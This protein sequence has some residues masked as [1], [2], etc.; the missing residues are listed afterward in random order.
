MNRPAL[1]LLPMHASSSRGMSRGGMVPLNL[2]HNSHAS[3]ASCCI[4]ST[5]SLVDQVAVL[6]SA[7]AGNLAKDHVGYS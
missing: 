4:G 1:L 6:T 5:D 3:R 2:K 7:C